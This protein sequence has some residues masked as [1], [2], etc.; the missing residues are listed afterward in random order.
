LEG[1]GEIIGDV[2][3]SPQRKREGQLISGI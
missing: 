1:T 3:R 2:G